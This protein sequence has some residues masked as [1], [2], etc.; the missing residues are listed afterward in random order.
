MADD[1]FVISQES[2]QKLKDDGVLIIE[3]VFSEKECDAYCA[4]IVKCFTQI[5]PKLHVD[6]RTG[7]ADEMTWKPANLPP[8]PRSGLFQAI[9][10]VFP[11]VLEIRSHEKIKSIFSQ[12]YSFLR[13]S[14]QTSFFTS[15]DGINVRPHIPAYQTDKSKDWAHL[16]Q[17]IRNN[18][19]LCVQG[20]IVLSNTT[21][22]FRASPKS[23]LLHDQILDKFAV[24]SKDNWFKLDNS[25]YGELK[26][27]VESIGGQW[28]I[29]IR[30]PRGSVILWLSSLIHSA[31]TQSKEKLSKC[32]VC[33]NDIWRDWRM[34][35]YVCYRPKEDVRNRKVHAKRLKKCLNEGRVTNHWGERMF[36]KKLF[37]EHVE[38]DSSIQIYVDDPQKARILFENAVTS[39][40]AKKF[41]ALICED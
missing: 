29:P 37:R 2:L 20:Q 5:S 41:V 13:E 8:M 7:K 14:P 36:P 26:E 23:H 31:M 33:K 34:V 11:P 3:N 40:V 16:D 4:E 10:S 18:P 6:M 35:V 21:A 9:V 15:M 1:N 30:A 27:M 38:R 19:Y 39:D 28:Q 32:G 17:T 22:C 25:K 24:N 12:V